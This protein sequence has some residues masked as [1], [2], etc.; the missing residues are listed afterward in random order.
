VLGDG[1]QQSVLVAEV[2]VD[3]RWLHPG[4]GGDR[5]GAHRVGAAALQQLDG[6]LDDAPAGAVGGV[7]ERHVSMISESCFQC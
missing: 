3:G 1:L 4:R 6:R 5:T 7:A 2:A